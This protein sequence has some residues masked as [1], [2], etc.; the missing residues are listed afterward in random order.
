MV[1]EPVEA[2]T[3]TL[4]EETTT[5]EVDST[6]VEA[7]TEDAGVVGAAL[8]DEGATEEEES[9]AQISWVTWRVVAAS[10]A[11][12][13]VKTQVSAPLVI[14]CWFADSHW[15]AVSVAAQEVSSAIAVRIHG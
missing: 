6:V 13:E 3:E 10:V 15:Q 9:A 7:G 12:Q 14:A 5:E 2:D 1:V 11:E 4:V 8:V